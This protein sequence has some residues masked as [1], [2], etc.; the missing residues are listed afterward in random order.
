[1]CSKLCEAPG[2]LLARGVVCGTEA[3]QLSQET[4]EGAVKFLARGRRTLD[5]DVAAYCE[6]AGVLREGGRSDL[7]IKYI[8]RALEVPTA[9]L[10]RNRC[11]WGGVTILAVTRVEDG[12]KGREGCCPAITHLTFA[13]GSWEYIIFNFRLFSFPHPSVSFSSLLFF[14]GGGGSER[15]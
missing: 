9:P 13:L 7:A 14:W 6:E 2:H 10:P 8:G 1:M 4:L 12:L 5:R 11:R 15:A 3:L